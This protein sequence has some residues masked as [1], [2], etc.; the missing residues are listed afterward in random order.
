M[1]CLG[2]RKVYIDYDDSHDHDDSHD[3]DDVS[4]SPS[5]KLDYSL[6]QST[7]DKQTA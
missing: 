3:D 6:T 5:E 1:M 7:E 4:R 2:L